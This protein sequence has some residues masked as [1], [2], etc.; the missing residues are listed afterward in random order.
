M[1]KDIMRVMN[2]T[3]RK[4]KPKDLYVILH[5]QHRLASRYNVVLTIKEIKVLSNNIKKRLILLDYVMKLSWSRI[6]G[7]MNIKGKEVIVV[8]NTK[9]HLLCTALPAIELVNI[10]KGE[11]VPR[12]III[13]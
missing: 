12:H 10:K 11:Y 6:V 8:Y 13:K 1:G 2:N 7:T 3:K 9:K 4:K 5:F